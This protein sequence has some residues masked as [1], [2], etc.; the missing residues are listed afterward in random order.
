MPRWFL[1]YH[2]PNQALAEELKAAIERKD[3]SSRVFF[4]PT[5][6]RAGRFWS[7]ALADEIAQADAFILLVGEKGLGPWQEL[8]YDEAL[9]RRVTSPDFPLVLVLLE[10]QTAPGLPF[11][12]RMHWVVT[13]DPAA[14]VTRLID[15]VSS[16]ATR[17]GELWRY[18]APYR[19]LAAMTEADSDYFFG[20]GNET[21][22]LLCALAAGPDRLAVLIGNSGVGK[23]SLA[24]AGGL[25][26]LKRQAWPEEAGTPT[27]WPQAFG[28]SRR[29]CFLTVRLGAEPLKALVESFFDTWRFGAAD[30]ERVNHQNGWI[31]LLQDGKATLC[32][33][34]DA[35]E[36]RHNELHQDKPSAFFLYIDQGEELYVRAKERERHR[37]SE[38]L[39]QA[40]SDP[41]LHSMMSLRSDFLGDLQRDEP[42]FAARQQIDVPPLREAELRK[43]ISRPAEL[44]SAS[45]ESEKLID[46]IARRAAED[47][48]KDVGALPLL[49]YTLDD[50]WTHMVKAGNG[51]L[52]LPV[53]AFELGGVL[54]DRA[55]DFLETRLGAE[56]ALR[57]ILTLK[58]ATV[59]ED[60]TLTR[61][62]APRSE[63]SNEEWRLVSELADHPNR[64]LV[65][66]TPNIG[67][68]Y[69]EV[70]HEA[71]F[72]RWDKLRDW[73]TAER[74]FLVWR[75]GLERDHRRW[76]AA[77]VD[78]KKDALLMGLALWQAQG[79]VGKRPD[80]LPEALRDFVMQSGEVDSKRREATRQ[81]EILRIKAEEEL[82]RLH[83]EQEAR[84]QR[85]RADAGDRARREAEIAASKERV[86]AQR[87]RVLVGVLSVAIIG[88]L[89]AWQYQTLKESYYWLTKVRGYVLT[90]AQESKLRPKDSFKECA[91]DCPEMV[92]IPPGEFTM[93]SPENEPHRFPYE[94]PQRK[95][96]IGYALAV[97]KYEVTFDDW[98][99][100]VAAGACPDVSDAGFGKRQQP[101]ISVSYDDA[102]TYVAWLTRMTG[103]TYRLLS[104]AEWEYAARAGTTTV[105]FWGNQIG[106]NNADCREC[107]SRW[108]GKQPA[109]VGQF[110]HNNFGL[111]DMAGNVWQWT[112]DCWHGVGFEGAPADGSAWMAGGGGN[113]NSHMVRGGAWDYLPET[114]ST[115]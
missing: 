112:E 73:I 62:S 99:A 76:E 111:Y 115:P 39:A 109:P 56:A 54:V 2:S 68:A 70:A 61:R 30:P 19:G 91:K 71:I 64:L 55:T 29:W 87:L 94:G 23:S 46:I 6:L 11:L 97:S 26:A 102:Q 8:E 1:S 108:D 20:R 27:V 45:F 95:V 69:A 98:D 59:Q 101:V 88:G 33:L 100:C 49:S 17:P 53:Q 110:N 48:A 9:D 104:D 80:D 66:V 32:D 47:S 37:F 31:K 79:W 21:V 51:V 75:S 78:S 4:A 90:V 89:A 57:R 22:D 14:D 35:T 83:A 10:G 96:T 24:R 107:G 28:A 81:A 44:L 12:R 77:P 13:P 15:A 72:R 65:I 93:G 86:H 63:F 18:A 82:A 92:V 38:I 105:Y 67:E 25:A 58:L 84:E 7:R 106:I 3:T 36:R 43:V 52:R 40:L 34:L 16:A 85:E 50:M 74:E 60:G 42:L 41:R 114:L 103:K 5:G 113:C